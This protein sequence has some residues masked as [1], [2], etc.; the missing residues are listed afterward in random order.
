MFGRRSKTQ[1]AKDAVADVSTNPAVPVAG[2][3]GF[4][5]LGAALMRRRQRKSSAA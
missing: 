5:L 4:T 1:K 2:A 3:V